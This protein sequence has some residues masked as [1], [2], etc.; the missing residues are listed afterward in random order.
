MTKT[1]TDGGCIAIALAW[2]LGWATGALRAFVFMKGWEWFV[3]DTFNVPELHFIQAWGLVYLVGF[4]T[5][6][7]NPVTESK[8]DPIVSAIL[9]L[10]TSVVWSTFAFVAM[11][12]LTV[13]L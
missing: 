5:W 1:T 11:L 8:V 3:A 6:Q 9:A 7:Q 10:V 13:F 12:I 4:A 2:I